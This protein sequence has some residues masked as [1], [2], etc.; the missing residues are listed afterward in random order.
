M[1]KGEGLGRWTMDGDQRSEVGGLN[2]RSR[3]AEN[4]KVRRLE[5]D[6]SRRSEIRGRGKLKA[7]SGAAKDEGR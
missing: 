1:G 4:Q 3:R 2:K 6:G 7:E 5:G